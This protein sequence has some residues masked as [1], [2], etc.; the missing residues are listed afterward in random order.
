MLLHNK[1][2]IHFNLL[3]KSECP[4]ISLCSVMECKA[5]HYVFYKSKSVRYN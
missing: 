5:L 4:V 3:K 1:N 2:I